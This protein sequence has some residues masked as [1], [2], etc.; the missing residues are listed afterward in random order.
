MP[1]LPPPPAPDSDEE[2]GDAKALVPV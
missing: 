2:Q 1:G